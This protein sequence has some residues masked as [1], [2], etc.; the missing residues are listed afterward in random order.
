MSPTA[1]VVGITPHGIWLLVDERESFLSFARFPWFR[2]APVRAVLTV[3]R[4]HPH[5]LRWPELDVDL[6][7][8]SIEDPDKY[9]LV[10]KP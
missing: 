3:E 6:H 7:L 9:P 2:E 4:P 1:E 8:E 10:A 5:H